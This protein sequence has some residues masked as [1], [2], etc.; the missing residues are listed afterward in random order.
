MADP[1]LAVAD[2]YVRAVYDKDVEAFV[3]LF[4]EQV[5]IF[6]MWNV[7]EY[8]GRS[9][10]RDMVEEWFR[11]LG[12]DRVAVTFDEW[13]ITVHERFASASAFV[14]YAAESADGKQLRS[15]QNR[16]SWVLQRRDDLWLV[17]HEHSSGPASFE[18]GKVMMSRPPASG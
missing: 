9:A 11:S 2:R 10:W 8:R 3:A 7:W 18:N 13:E 16:L 5:R 17:I 15:M 4:D 6:D 1:I 14:R 12:S